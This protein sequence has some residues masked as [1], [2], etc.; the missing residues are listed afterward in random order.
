M[1]VTHSCLTLQHHGPYSLWNSPGQNT[2]VGSHS[3]LQGI[4]PTQES[5]W[6]LLHCRWILYQL[7]YQVLQ[8]KKKSK[9]RQKIGLKQLS[10]KDWVIRLF[11]VVRIRIYHHSNREGLT[12][13]EKHFPQTSGH[14]WWLLRHSV[15]PWYPLEDKHDIH[16]DET[17]RLLSKQFN[18]TATLQ[19]LRRKTG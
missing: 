11:N 2:G 6:G 7:S 3:L 10:E 13:T 9:S 15:T 16:Q 8:V 14:V 19:E 4:L 1:K 17:F 5:N 12:W 18:S